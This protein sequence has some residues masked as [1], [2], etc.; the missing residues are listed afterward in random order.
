MKAHIIRFKPG[1]QDENY[2]YLVEYYKHKGISF[3]A[4]VN[5]LIAKE[6]RRLMKVKKWT[7]TTNQKDLTG[8][9]IN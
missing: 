4:G 9:V 2:T 3:S 6:A 5:E 7:Q 8:Y 1:Q